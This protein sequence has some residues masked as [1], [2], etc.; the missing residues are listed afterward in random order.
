[1]RVTSEKVKFADDGTIKITGKDW[2]VLVERLKENFKEILAWTKKWRLKLSIVKT[3]FCMFSLSNQVLE[4][5]RD[6]T[7][8]I[9]RHRHRRFILRRIYI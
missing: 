2:H 3:E 1:M 4:E 6:H 7:F 9:D 5:A 8:V